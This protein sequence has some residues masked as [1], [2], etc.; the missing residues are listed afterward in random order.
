MVIEG[1]RVRERYLQVRN[2][3]E[4]ICSPLTAEDHVVQPIVDVSPP[5]WHLGHT[6][7]FFETL[8]LA[9]NDPDYNVFDDNYGFLFNSYY[10]TVGA[11]TI[12]TDRG[13]LTRPTV[14]EILEYRSYVDEKMEGFLEK[15]EDPEVLELIELGIQHEQQHQELLFYDIKYILGNNPL[16][17]VYVSN[18]ISPCTTELSSANDLIIEEGV[19]QIGHQEENFHFDNEKGVHNVFLHSC[20]LQDRLITNK[21]YI[22]FIEDGGYSDF[23]FWLSEGWDWVKQN[24]IKAPFHWH[25]KE[26]DWFMYSL[27]GGLVKVDLFAPVIHISFFEADAYAKWSGLR[28]PT[29]F[30][31]EVACNQYGTIDK[32]TNF[33]E[34]N[35]YAPVSPLNG[36]NQLYGDV[37]EWTSSAYRPYPYYKAPEG[38]VGEYNGKFM[39]NQM[40]LRGGSCATS[41][42]HIRNTYRNFFHPHL[43]WMFSGVRLA[44]DL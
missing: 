37:W 33:M 35:H 10:E 22:E 11:R 16:F 34:S 13:N 21:E 1:N 2:Q 7:W 40:V 27:N 29:E 24:A 23:R 15:V 31:W 12:R 42:T 6:T 8:V 39:V 19:Y 26:G 43:R 4:Q 14:K 32:Q 44:K 9:Q 38:A 28:M 5:K 30:E 20:A 18:Y 36:N 25:F 3:S 17:P 41:R